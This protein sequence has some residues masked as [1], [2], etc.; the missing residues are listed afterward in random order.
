MTNE[1]TSFRSL[2]GRTLRRI[3]GQ[4]GKQLRNRPRLRLSILHTGNG[5]PVDAEIVGHL[6]LRPIQLLAE[7]SNV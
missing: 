7:C 4:H 2:P 1:T 3:L 5:G 6:S